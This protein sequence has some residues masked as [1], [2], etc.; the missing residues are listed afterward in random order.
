MWI[1]A[2]EKEI[3]DNN[4]VYHRS[5]PALPTHPAGES[6]SYYLD[7]AWPVMEGS[8]REFQWESKLKYD[9]ALLNLDRA[10]YLT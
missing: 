8:D 7:L 5:P 9:V 4:A 2:A 3:G 1:Q 10:F 6:K